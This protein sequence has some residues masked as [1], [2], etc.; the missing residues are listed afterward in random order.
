MKA[1]LREWRDRLEGLQ[2][3]WWR[4]RWVGGL[5]PGRRP[6]G[7]IARGK[8]SEYRLQKSANS[9]QDGRCGDDRELNGSDSRMRSLD[10]NCD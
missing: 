2:G 8:P 7:G 10:W 3:W 1:K 5:Q 9:W 4:P 6:G